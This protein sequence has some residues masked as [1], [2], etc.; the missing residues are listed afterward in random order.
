[1]LKNTICVTI[2]ILINFFSYSQSI[3][4]TI[5]DNEQNPIEYSYV[6]IK[7]SDS[8]SVKEYTIARE[9]K[10][11]ID[12]KKEYLKTI[13]EI[14]AN[15]YLTATEI[16]E[17]P[18]K[19]KQY[20]F[21]FVLQRDSINYTL[22]E[23]IIVAEKKP[24]T[25]KKD[26]VSYNVD[27][28]RDGSERKIEDIIKK[29]PGIEVDNNT[30]TIKYKGKPIEN[31]TLDGD[32]LFGHN[33]T[34]GTK[35]INVD[36]VE[37]IEAIENYSENPLLK[38]IEK[39]DKVSLNLKLKENKISFSGNVDL[40]AG[41]SE[42]GNGVFD[43]N[44]NLLG[45]TKSYKSF[46][47]TSYND[48]GVN[49]SPFNY[50]GFN[51]N[52]EQYVDRRFV[53]RK[54]IP[55]TIFVNRL[56][57]ERINNNKQYFANYNAMFKLN[58]RLSVKT[59]LYFVK[60]NII[61]HQFV[62]NRNILNN[63]AFITTDNTSINKKPKQYRGDL[64]MKYN[65]GEN[66]LLEYR[67]S[68]RQEAIQTPSKVVSNNSNN[69]SSLLDSEDFYLNQKVVFTKKISE[70]K[71]FQFSAFQSSNNIPQTLKI[72]P[73][74]LYPENFSTD[75]QDVR[76]SKNSLEVLSTLLGSTSNKNKYTLSIG[77]YS[78]KNKLNTKLFSENPATLF[79]QV[80]STTNLEYLKQAVNSGGAYHF[81]I[82]KWEFSPSYSLMVLNQE[83]FNVE[84][85]S[86]LAATNFLLSPNF[87]IKYKLNDVSSFLGSVNYNRSSMAEN[88]LYQNEILINNRISLSS[89][90][91]LEL[92]E[93]LSY[94]L[95]YLHN[96]IYNLLDLSL[97]TSYQNYK[98]NFFTDFTI[99]ENT[100]RI[101]YFYLPQGNDNLNFNFYVMKY[102]RFLESTIKLRSN[103]SIS[104]Y[105]NIV[106][107]SEL[108][109]NK[110]QFFN[111]ELNFKTA[112]MFFINFE[113]T[114]G[115]SRSTSQSD[116]QNE[117]INESLNNVFKVILKPSKKWW[118][119]LST[120][121]FLPSLDEKS[122]N[123][124]FMD[125][126][127]RYRPNNKKIEF[128]LIAKNLFNE[129][130]FEQIQ[131]SDFSTN[132]YRTNILPRYCLLSLTYD[133]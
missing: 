25:V 86:K 131:T 64:E 52:R 55:E 77:G 125:A 84:N 30:G 76:H 130:N 87:N 133:F 50:F 110:S 106:N 8:T 21:S 26:T 78:N 12:L 3:L 68:V 32:N 10:F 95:T 114:I 58:D 101:N 53:A 5:N 45:I 6:L 126:T 59:N 1:M 82:H 109:N 79:T 92:Q 128:S 96:D 17:N 27:S 38:G 113:N 24:L 71:A 123:Y 129:T 39:G 117:F 34:L 15:G 72:N 4:G 102:I 46:A 44:A 7:D 57:E 104:R 93:V 62:E 127:V 132:I 29:L 74:V 51:Q 63:E 91:S 16:I 89:I 112:L 73:S 116:N 19:D 85:S 41:V 99:S 37:E 47:T 83:I 115:L 13:I 56:D 66:S 90:P 111:T 42:R 120:E 35:N 49:R 108:R 54:I 40:G 9:G 75:T 107:D 36:M 31:V 69:F 14:Q 60:D 22:N 48:V 65:S 88:Y 67:L 105:K 124:T 122:E 98:G 18:D 81:N 94:G 119:Q 80:N 121:Y 118:I 103:Y 33:Y 61:S 28:Y 11:K 23:V 70:N 97:E 2:F 20:N 100:T 43:I